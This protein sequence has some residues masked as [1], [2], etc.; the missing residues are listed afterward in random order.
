[1]SLHGRHT[2]AQEGSR[3]GGLG[4]GAWVGGGWVGGA[5]AAKYA[6]FAKYTILDVHHDTGSISIRMMIL[7]EQNPRGSPF[8]Q[9]GAISNAVLSATIMIVVTT[10][11]VA[12]A[13]ITIMMMVECPGVQPLLLLPARVTQ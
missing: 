8:Y 7:G 10:N 5:G 13:M 6:M 1:M 2:D 3:G 12:N 11:M 4:G 9:S